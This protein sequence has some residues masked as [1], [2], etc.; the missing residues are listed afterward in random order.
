ME[1]YFFSSC[2]WSDGKKGSVNPKLVWRVVLLLAA[3]G[4]LVVARILVAAGILVAAVAS[5]NRYGVPYLDL[6][7]H[8]MGIKMF[9]V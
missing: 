7:H 8:H 4:I 3:V 2:R 6:I 5:S 9:D 1:L